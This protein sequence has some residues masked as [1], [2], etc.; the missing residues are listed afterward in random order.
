MARADYHGPRDVPGV[1]DLDHHVVGGAPI[2]LFACN[3]LTL[4]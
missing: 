2:L 1:A 3:S 4:G